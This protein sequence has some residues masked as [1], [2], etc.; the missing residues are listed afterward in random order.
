MVEIVQQ[1]Q[2]LDVD[3]TPLLEAAQT[4]SA[5]TFV[6]YLPPLLRSQVAELGP[7]GLGGAVP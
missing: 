1:L 3:C 5:D 2:T 7:L 6:P 4:G